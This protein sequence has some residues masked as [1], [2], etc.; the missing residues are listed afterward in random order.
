MFDFS[1]KN[2]DNRNYV[3][4]TKSDIGSVVS[5]VSGTAFSHKPGMMFKCFGSMYGTHNAMNSIN[6]RYS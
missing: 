6:L 5:E 4:S 2:E 1:S 3:A